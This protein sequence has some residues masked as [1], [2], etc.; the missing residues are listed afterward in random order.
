MMGFP[1]F[2]AGIQFLLLALKLIDVLTL[3]W[4]WVFSVFPIA[5]IAFVFWVGLKEILGIW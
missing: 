5:F 2:V 1:F 3:S 4:W